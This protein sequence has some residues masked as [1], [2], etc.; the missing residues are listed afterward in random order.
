[1]SKD[2]KSQQIDQ[3]FYHLKSINRLKTEEL[4]SYCY[5]G[6]KSEYRQGVSLENMDN[7]CFSNHAFT[8]DMYILYIKK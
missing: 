2:Y 7:V 3:N 1:M 6:H 8:F 4:I 5:Q